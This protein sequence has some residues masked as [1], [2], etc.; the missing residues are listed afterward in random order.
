MSHVYKD[1]IDRSADSSVRYEASLR[2]FGFEYL[3]N[4]KNKNKDLTVF[5]EP[6]LILKN[7][8]SKNLIEANGKCD[9]E[10]LSSMEIMIKR[11]TYLKENPFQ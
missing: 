6:P 8:L 2:Y 11:L 1:V 4:K 7:S 3:R 10:N 5:I 9:C